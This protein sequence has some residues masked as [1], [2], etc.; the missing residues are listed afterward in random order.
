ML[1][2]LPVLMI[3]SPVTGLPA[4][5]RNNCSDSTRLSK[6]L[7]GIDYDY[8]SPILLEKKQT[9]IPI[10]WK[11]TVAMMKENGPPAKLGWVVNWMN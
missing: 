5:Y 9:L 7:E 8:I 1:V 11:V 4:S 10:S 2:L 6:Y 3:C